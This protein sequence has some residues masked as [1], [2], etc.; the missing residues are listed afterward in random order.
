MYYV[1]VCIISLYS[2]LFFL[3]LMNNSAVRVWSRY[4][5]H[6]H[7]VES[8][9]FQ[10]YHRA[11]LVLLLARPPKK[12]SKDDRTRITDTQA[13]VLDPRDDDNV[14][15]RHG[16][17]GWFGRPWMKGAETTTRSHVVS[18]LSGCLMAESL[19]RSRNYYDRQSWSSETVHCPLRQL[20]YHRVTRRSFRK[21]RI[22]IRI[23]M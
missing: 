8:I 17:N 3:I 7:V 1:H 13:F 6:L 19:N 11:I 4:C 20:P 16:I 23:R 9:D 18:L 14:L 12:P 21:I 2:Y 15:L 10:Q 22:R 5:T